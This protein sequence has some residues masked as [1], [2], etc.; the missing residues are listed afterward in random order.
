MPIFGAL[1]VE[2]LADRVPVIGSLADEDWETEDAR[3]LT[4]SYEVDD[5]RRLELLPPALH[6]SIPLYSQVTVRSHGSSPAGAFELAELRLMSR[7][8]AHYGG[9][10]TGAFASTPEAV[11]LL[12]EHYGW[13]VQLAEVSLTPRYHGAQ[14]VVRADGRTLLDMSMVHPQ[15]VTPDDLLVT[16]GFHLARVGADLRLI[17]SEPSYT[18]KKVQRG[19]PHITIIDT[20]AF[21]DGRVKLVTPIVAT[22]LEGGFALGRVRFLM[23]PTR[24]AVE[25]TQRL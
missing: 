6:P 4:L 12:R 10:T 1:E 3:A 11:E 19:K 7:A 13:A 8:G 25:G 23:D 14:A 9:Y 18:I 20:E 21:G 2:K 5:T 24:P 15:P 16:A 22:Y 17:Q